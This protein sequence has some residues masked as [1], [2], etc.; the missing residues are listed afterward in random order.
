MGTGVSGSVE[1]EGVGAGG[2][3]SEEWDVGGMG[4][5]RLR[6][7]G[8]GGVGVWRSR[9]VMMN[10]GCLPPVRT[11]EQ[12]EKRRRLSAIGAM[13]D[14]P[15]QS[16]LDNLPR[17]DLQHMALLLYERLPTIFGLSKSCCCWRGSTT[18]RR[19]VDDFVSNGGVF[20]DSQ[21]GHYVRNNTLMSSKEL[22]DR[23]REYVW[24]N[25]APQGRPNLTAGAGLTM[26]Y[27]Q[28]QS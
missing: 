2:S 9:S 21:Q 8:L 19:W 6:E 25:A 20:S 26:N 11:P 10:V 17:N 22:C 15:V 1:V 27:R 14:K 23:A 3:G 24:E 28:T 18:V 13:A 4:V 7:R 5:W 12:C 16:G